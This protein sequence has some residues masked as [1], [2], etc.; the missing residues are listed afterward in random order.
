M[1]GGRESQSVSAPRERMFAATS[2]ART[3][4]KRWDEVWSAEPSST[5]APRAS[6][7]ARNDHC[8]LTVQVRPLDDL[9]WLQ[10]VFRDVTAFEERQ[11]R[12]ATLL[13]GRL[14]PSQGRFVLQ[15]SSCTARPGLAAPCVVVR[16]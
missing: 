7:I 13:T 5:P 6:D 14:C 12:L 4:C 10:E 1:P 15:A 8:E 2:A 16:L 11:L 3:D 9:W